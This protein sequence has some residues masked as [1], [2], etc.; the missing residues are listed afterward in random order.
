MS[1]VQACPVRRSTEGHRA[2]PA[3]YLNSRSLQGN[4]RRARAQYPR[5]A[6]SRWRWSASAPAGAHGVREGGLMIPARFH[7]SELRLIV[8]L[9]GVEALIPKQLGRGWA[10]PASGRATASRE[11][12]SRF[13]D[14]PYGTEPPVSP[15]NPPSRVGAYARQ[16]VNGRGEHHQGRRLHRF[17]SMALRISPSHGLGKV[18]RPGMCWL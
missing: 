10:R 8:D 9:G 1:G 17:P 18:S 13:E 16:S 11:R 4:P 15:R 12:Y 7:P 2:I 14:R 6:T 3:D 5:A